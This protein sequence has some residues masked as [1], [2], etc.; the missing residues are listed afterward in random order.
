[1]VEDLLGKNTCPGMIEVEPELFRKINEGIDW[2][3]RY[4]SKILKMAGIDN[5]LI[6]NVFLQK[7]LNKGIDNQTI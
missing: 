4:E 7:I 3:L 1:M 5:L 6:S 2:N